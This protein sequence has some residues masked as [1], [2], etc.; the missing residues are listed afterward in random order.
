MKRLLRGLILVVLTALGVFLP[1]WLSF[2]SPVEDYTVFLTKTSGVLPQVAG[3]G[4]WVWAWEGL[5]PTNVS[6]LRFR[7]QTWRESLEVSGALEQA[8]RYAALTGEGGLFQFRLRL[9]LGLQWDP[10]RLPQLVRELGLGSVD[11]ERLLGDWR[12][13]LTD[14]VRTWA[15]QRWALGD[16]EVSGGSLSEE[17]KRHL[18][19][20]LPGPYRW[21]RLVEVNVEVLQRPDV[22][23]YAR[24]RS[25]AAF[26]DE[27]VEAAQRREGLVYR[28]E[29]AREALHWEGLER[30]GQLLERHPQLG[31]VLK[32]EILPK[33]LSS[34]AP[35]R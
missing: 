19:G 21:A 22:E 27:A 9:E 17:L 16:A 29:R 13:T 33:S 5:L 30:L 12:P 26:L 10:D 4:R 32:P 7:G 31:P 18:V 23:L 15:V 28:L 35:L 1:G 6:T 34:S 11:E 8:W 25:L 2:W 3:R 20:L 14:R 24:M